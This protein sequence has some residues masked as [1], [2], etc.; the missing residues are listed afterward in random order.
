M[1]VV[2]CDYW[3]GSTSHKT[4]KNGNTCNIKYG[5]N[6]IISKWK[7]TK[8]VEQLELLTVLNIT[9]SLPRNLV[10]WDSEEWPYV[11]SL[12]PLPPEKNHTKEKIHKLWI[13]LFIRSFKNNFKRDEKMGLNF[14]ENLEPFK[15]NVS[16][17][18][19]K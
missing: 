17:T 1:P 5:F 4:T 14:A 9:I 3:S 19:K 12:R 7:R 13:A 10:L 8:Q 2:I 15:N 11:R 18:R 16:L 6:G